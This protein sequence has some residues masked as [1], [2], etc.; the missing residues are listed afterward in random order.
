MEGVTQGE[1]TMNEHPDEE[2]VMVVSGEL[3]RVEMC[4]AA[5]QDAGI[6]AKVVGN[7]LDTGLGTALSGSVE[8][9]VSKDDEAKAVEVIKT[10]EE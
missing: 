3:V 7:E 4:K 2:I 6:D 8:L 1:P 10:V 5:L 9:W